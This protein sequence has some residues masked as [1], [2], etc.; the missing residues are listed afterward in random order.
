[1]TVKGFDKFSKKLDELSN[2]ANK[3]S[4]TKSA[5]MGEILT[6]EFVSRHT[7]FS[8]IDELFKAGGFG[9]E[10][11]AQF[12]AIPEDQLDAFI[13][14]ESPYQSWREMLNAAGAEWAKRKLGL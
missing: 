14:T 12:E 1:M 10:S 8:N 7:R 13:R 3:L 11:Q 5:S 9:A 2:N 4:E 6:P